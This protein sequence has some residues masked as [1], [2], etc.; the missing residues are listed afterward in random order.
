VGSNCTYEGLDRV[1]LLKSQHFFS[2][3]SAAPLHTVEYKPDYPVETKPYFQE[4]IKFCKQAHHP[5]SLQSV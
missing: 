2:E 1:R 5:P 4:L 3:D